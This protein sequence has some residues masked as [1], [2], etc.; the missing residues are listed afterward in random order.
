MMDY[1]VH[2][3][4]PLLSLANCVLFNTIN[5]RSKLK[6]LMLV[7]IGDGD[8]TSDHNRARWHDIAYCFLPAAP[9]QVNCCCDKVA[10]ILRP[11][12]DHHCTGSLKD[13]N[14]HALLILSNAF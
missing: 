7:V 3:A 11:T 12:I 6:H 4:L 5:A 1:F 9:A 14:S 8:R 2:H 10:V 13:A